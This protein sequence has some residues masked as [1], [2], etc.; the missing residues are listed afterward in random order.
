[1]NSFIPKE[2]DC[3]FT[4]T[5]KSSG[6]R[7]KYGFAAMGIN[8][9]LVFGIGSSRVLKNLSMNPLNMTHYKIGFALWSTSVGR[10]VRSKVERG[11]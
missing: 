10:L 4:R 5:V 3:E 9:V 2:T 6:A 7:S 11:G 1:M 8:V